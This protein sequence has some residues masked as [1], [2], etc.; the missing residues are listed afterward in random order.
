MGI[1]KEEVSESH[2]F[3]FYC[4]PECDFK[5]GTRLEFITDAIANHPKSHSYITH[6][7]KQEVKDNDQW[8]EEDLGGMDYLEYNAD[9]KE[10]KGVKDDGYYYYNDSDKVGTESVSQCGFKVQM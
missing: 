3:L 5:N 1:K 4:C 2:E 6:G 10:E 9:T 8:I 7:I